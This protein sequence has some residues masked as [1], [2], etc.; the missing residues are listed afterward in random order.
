MDEH[1]ENFNKE[2][3]NT[4]RT[5]QLKDTVT[6]VKYTLEGINRL[7][8][9]EEQISNLKTG[10]CKSTNQSIKKKKNLNEDSLRNHWDIRHTNIHILWGPRRREGK[11]RDR[12]PI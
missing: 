11:K 10:Y 9:A 5:H 6:E 2:V 3:E 4:K 8:D 7:D 12:N 1:S